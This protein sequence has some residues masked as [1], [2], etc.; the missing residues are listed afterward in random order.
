MKE[1]HGGVLFRCKKSCGMKKAV[2]CGWSRMHN[3]DK[4]W[5]PYVLKETSSVRTAEFAWHLCISKD[6]R[7]RLV[8]GARELE[9]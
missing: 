1:I 9:F 7:E 4:D 8:F 6:G 5:C 2:K 3:R